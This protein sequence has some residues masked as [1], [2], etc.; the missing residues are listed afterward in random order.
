M[1]LLIVFAPCGCKARHLIVCSGNNHGVTRP[2]KREVGFLAAKM[3]D[4]W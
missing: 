1:E 2:F 3:T 4:G